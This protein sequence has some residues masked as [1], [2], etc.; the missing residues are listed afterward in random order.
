MAAIVAQITIE[1]K[2]LISFPEK[3]FPGPPIKHDYVLANA[4]TMTRA[5]SRDRTKCRTESRTDPD[6]ESRTL[7][8]PSSVIN[9]VWIVLVVAKT[10]H[11]F[12]TRA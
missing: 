5:E 12:H 2:I 9:T 4:A 11:T 6:P 8:L 7:R 3:N 10:A 1:F